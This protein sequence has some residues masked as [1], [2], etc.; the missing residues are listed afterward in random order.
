MPN[1]WSDNVI[2]IYHGPHCADGFAAAWVV[3]Q[4]FNEKLVDL[5]S[6]HVEFVAMDYTNAVQKYGQLNIEDKDIIVVDFSFN[7]GIMA[8]MLHRARCVVVL[9]HHKSAKETLG[10][11]ASFGVS[12]VSAIDKHYIA[13]DMSRSGA[14]MAWE[15]FFPEL[16]VPRVLAYVQDRDL[17]QKHYQDSFAFHERWMVE[18]NANA[19]LERKFQKFSKLVMYGHETERVFD[20][21]QPEFQRLIHEGYLLTEAKQQEMR[22]HV[23]YNTKIWALFGYTQVPVINAPGSWA[24]D[25][26][27]MLVT[28]HNS[29]A[30]VYTIGEGKVKFSVRSRDDLDDASAVAKHF[31]GGGHRNAAGFTVDH[32]KFTDMFVNGSIV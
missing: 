6:P 27:N 21:N 4:Y 30:L 28:K 23:E 14:V 32:G 20:G 9:D 31:G 12:D 5:P 16:E 19:F 8:D 7:E 2:C 11:L 15:Y 18:Q 17:W 13:F 24:S 26:G 25:I 29:L 3:N 10:R 1:K 22:V